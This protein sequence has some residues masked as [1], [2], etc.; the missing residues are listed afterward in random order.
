MMT[1]KTWNTLAPE[2]R[3]EVINKTGYNVTD[4]LLQPYH[5]NFDYDTTGK[6]LKSILECCYLRPSDKKIVVSIEV[7]PKYATATAKQPAKKS[8]K[9][10][11]KTPCKPLERKKWKFRRY[12]QDDPDDGEWVWAYGYTEAEAR[13]E[14]ESEYWNTVRLECYGTC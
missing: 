4:A 7:T 2:T 5:H 14:I 6:K 12:T 10:A 3:R 9:S 1:L 11:T 8:V 13:Q